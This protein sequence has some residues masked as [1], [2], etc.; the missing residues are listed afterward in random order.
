MNMSETNAEARLYI[1]KAT[2]LRN[3]G[4]IEEA[5]LSAK[6]AITLDPEDANAWWQ[7]ALC[8]E[9]KDGLAPSIKALEKTVEFAP[10]F[11]EGWCQLGLAYKKIS[12]LDKAIECYD[13]AL[14]GDDSHVR[15]LKLL[16]IALKDRDY[17]QD[18]ISRLKILAS[19]H[20]LGELDARTSFDYAFLLSEQKD[21]LASI[22]IYEINTQISDNP[23]GSYNNLGYNYERLGR[24]LDSIDAF[25]KAASLDESYEL[26][27]NNIGKVLPRLLNLRER[28][29]KKSP[30]LEQ[31]SWFKHYINPFELLGIED[32]YEVDGDA[33][34]LQKY[35]QAL[36]REI[37]LED[38]KV[39]WMPGLIADKST[40]MSICEQL[41]DHILFEYH[42]AIFENKA[43]CGF[44]SRGALDHFLVDPDPEN[45]VTLPHDLDRDM[46]AWLGGR[47]SEQ[48]N[49]VFSKSIENGDL[50]VIECMLDGRR[51]VLPENEDRCFEGARRAIE[52]MVEPL[53]KLA[54]AASEK[55]NVRL[56]DV[57]NALS[58]KRFNQ[59]LHLLPA[60]FTETHSLV[61][62]ALRSIS[63]SIY[64]SQSDAEAAK[65]IIE[66][67]RFAIEKS[68]VIAH[69][70]REDTKILEEK[71]QEEKAKEAHLTFG[72][73]SLDIT[74]AGVSYGGRNISKNDLTAARWGMVITSNS[75]RT[76]RFSIA[77]K[78]RF[79]NDI[80]VSWS[81]S[82]IE[83][84]KKLWTSLVDA[85][86]NYLF[87]DLIVNFKK[88][89][90]SGVKT[91]V[92]PLMVTSSGVEFEVDGWFSKKKIFCPW[93]RLN[94]ELENGSLI[95]KHLSERKATASLPLETVDNALVLHFL[96]SDNS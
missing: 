90:N 5:L 53:E 60:E 81:S 8:Q 2:E 84:Q 94:T 36:Y 64:N 1:K 54:K 68:P 30:Y 21:Y 73:K 15:T 56:T 40:A 12:M 18:K 49:L 43:L 25:R 32:P 29:L 87:D 35:K 22:K 55:M 77:F 83:E 71:I 76:V 9:L 66:L 86:I 4:R 75:P 48:F 85:T 78:D 67:G 38:G 88:R 70:F 34:A 93:N 52:R 61:Y 7:V 96:A 13:R 46:L 19:L 92:G 82:Q 39:D 26:P 58:V 6:K 45:T 20:E 41:S 95:V 23:T 33:K 44:L 17:A 47:F 10:Y 16:D 89:L 69:Q 63:I 37:E 50:E 31:S 11:T 14:E 24:D 65:A 51:W 80:S 28:S 57:Q 59:I 91:M 72:N 42:K 62:G 79:D 74:K 27:K 3:E